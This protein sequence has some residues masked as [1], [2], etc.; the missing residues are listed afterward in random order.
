MSVK[1]MEQIKAAGPLNVVWGA[2]C[3]GG[4]TEINWPI[5]CLAELWRLGRVA[6]LLGAKSDK[7]VAKSTSLV[8]VLPE[9]YEKDYPELAAAA[10]PCIYQVDR[11]DAATM[12]G[13]IAR[14]AR[15]GPW[16]VIGVSDDQFG[17][18]DG[19]KDVQRFRQG[20]YWVGH[21][22]RAAPAT[23][24]R[25]FFNNERN[26][27]FVSGFDPASFLAYLLRELSEFPPKL[28]TIAKGIPCGGGSSAVTPAQQ[29]YRRCSAVQSDFCAFNNNKA[30]VAR[31]LW[32]QAATARGE[33]YA[34][35]AE[36]GRVAWELNFRA[37][38]VPGYA[39]ATF[40]QVLAKTRSPREAE[41]LLRK[42]LEWIEC[43]PADPAMKPFADYSKAE[44][45]ALLARYRTGAAADALFAR[46]EETLRGE[47]NGAMSDD[48]RPACLG[49]LLF[50]WADQERSENSEAVFERGRRDYQQ[51][52][53]IRYKADRHSRYAE[54]LWRRGVA[55]GG[56]A[57]ERMFADARQE[58]EPLLAK[59]PTN[60]GLLQF[61]GIIAAG[62]GRTEEA[63]QLLRK[64]IALQPAD[65]G[66]LLVSWATALGEAGKFEEAEAIFRES[67]AVKPDSR[68]L[69]KNWSSILIWRARANGATEW[70]D[71]A[72]E[73]AEKAE[74]VEVGSGAYNLAC[75]AGELG[76]RNGVEQ[77]M[78]RSTEYGHMMGLS[79]VLRD[80]SFERFRNE[81]WFRALLSQVFPLD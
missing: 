25:E 1:S 39:A 45:Y 36:Q 33:E 63:E 28:A 16:L 5:I 54:A 67:E 11:A 13:L 12:A 43:Y 66:D 41:P 8:N 80:E 10:T 19:I 81:A 64:A 14:G 70:F 34:R 4:S 60:P 20:L 56:E 35:L 21:Y 47:T 3:S 71:R 7:S 40:T 65:G 69:R 18:A 51:A 17:L 53:Q 73:Q 62:Q 26:A 75:I 57:G 77:W 38:P 23:L 59:M 24:G 58:V 30:E 78:M 31:K 76:D 29:L 32:T 46:A 74:A 37:S 15:T 27:R 68:A 79:H 2:G 22:D 48:F 44:A 6:R 72:R 9:L 42:G 49:D 55:L 52:Q 50:R 61:A